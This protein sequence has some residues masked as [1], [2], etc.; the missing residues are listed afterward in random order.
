VNDINGH[1][2]GDRLLVAIS[3]I[4]RERIRQNDTLCRWGGDEFVLL[5]PGMKAPSDL[6]RVAEALVHRMDQEVTSYELET[7]VTFSIGGAIFP[8]DADTTESLL[9][10]ADKALYYAKSQG[11]NNIQIYSEM[12]ER[13]IGFND[14]DMTQ[15]F[16][17]A[18]KSKAIQAHYQLIID[19]NSREPSGVEALARWHDDKYG[20][21][22]PQI[23]IPMAENIGL[24]EEVSQQVFEY[25]LRD[26]QE[27]LGQNR[28][29][30]LSVNLSARQLLSENFP[31]KLYASIENEFDVSPGQIKLEI[32][33]SQSLCT[34]Q[35]MNTLDKLRQLGFN[36]SLDDFGTGFSSLSN[37]DELPINELKIDMSFIKRLKTH[38][39]SLLLESIIQLG[40]S[41]NLELVAEG[42]E[43]QECA[44]ILVG[45]G[46]D[47]LQGFYF[48][49]P[50]PWS[51]YWDKL[52]YPAESTNGSENILEFRPL[53]E[54]I[55]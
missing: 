38:K 5:L 16:N 1:K 9:A 47:R 45:M 52:P 48:S 8:D 49:K 6:R 51:E 26:L 55:L 28:N 39:S 42:V 20:W 11:R 40:H 17:C 35:C 37:L 53:K 3:S 15:R 50:A 25:A 33:E 14:F 24:I 36:L 31:E 18:V 13:D 22:S 21:V 30:Y 23:F 46:V 32:T 27:Y 7:M 2:A 44:E 19:S 12:R 29:F 41:L 34:K 43:D 10:Q 4:M 54:E